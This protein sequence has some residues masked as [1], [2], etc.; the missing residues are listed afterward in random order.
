M[1]S[2]PIR[3]QDSLMISISG[4][5]QSIS[6]MFY[7]EI[8]S[9][10]RNTVMPQLLVKLKL[11]STYQRCFWIIWGVQLYILNITQKSRKV[12]L[13]S[14]C[15]NSCCRSKCSLPIGFQVYLIISTSK[16]SWS[17]S[18]FFFIEIFTKK[19]DKTE[20]TTF[21]HVYPAT[22]NTTFTQV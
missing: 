10:E 17:I 1:Q 14:I 11:A 22:E 18:Q 6:K 16:K 12:F 20:N 15:K 19:I 2:C 3:L 9:E 13:N 21:T 4:R 7:R 5:S 8:A